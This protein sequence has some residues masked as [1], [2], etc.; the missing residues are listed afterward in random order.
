MSGSCLCWRKEKVKGTVS[1]WEITEAGKPQ[2]HITSGEMVE[3][4]DQRHLQ[5]NFV[6]PTKKFELYPEKIGRPLKIW[7]FSRTP[8][9]KEKP[10]SYLLL[11]ADHFVFETQ[12]YFLINLP[13]Y[14][15]HKF[16]KL[17]ILLEQNGRIIPGKNRKLTFF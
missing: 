9:W 11:L 7:L 4:W 14:I 2:H 15:V 10:V 1:L 16:C 8:L 6:W 12:V 13:L 3:R 5:K 17:N